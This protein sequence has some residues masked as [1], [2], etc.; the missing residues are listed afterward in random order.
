MVAWSNIEI[1]H[2]FFTF[3]QIFSHNHH[4]WPLS[5]LS[6]TPSIFFLYFQ[7]NYLKKHISIPFFQNM[8]ESSFAYFCCTFSFIISL[9]TSMKN[10]G[11]WYYTLFFLNE[12][13]G[14]LYTS[15]RALYNRNFKD[16]HSLLNPIRLWG[17]KSF[18]RPVLLAHTTQCKRSILPIRGAIWLHRYS[19]WV[20][21]KTWCWRGAS[22]H[23]FAWKSM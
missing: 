10:L 4:S 20:N 5:Y 7:N 16:L 22:L 13:K 6:A 2:S 17:F 18:L 15:G 8:M 19:L 21:I 14:V 9:P 11:I 23:F 3:F 1:I 12:V